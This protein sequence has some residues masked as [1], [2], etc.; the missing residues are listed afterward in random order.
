[1][2]TDKYGEMSSGNSGVE[3]EDLEER[4]GKIECVL[5][6]LDKEVSSLEGCNFPD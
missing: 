4:L 6:E 3:V 5:G 1:M 2:A